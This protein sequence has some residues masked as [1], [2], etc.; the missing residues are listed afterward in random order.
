[1]KVLVAYMSQT[2][3]TKKVAQAIYE[4]IQGTKEMKEMKQVPNLDDYD[5]TFVG[6]PIM[7]YGP[8]PE[9]ANFLE[10][11]AAGK[12]IAIFITHSAPEEM[13]ELQ[14][15]I[16]KCV[17]PAAKA[18]VKGVFNCQGELGKD[19]ADF[20]LKSGNLA[21]E[22]W[23]KNRE[24]TLGQPDARRLERARIWAKDL[25]AKLDV[26]AKSEKR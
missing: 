12:N 23:A 14:E 5:L 7:R 21:L 4:A 3:Q 11:K 16:N 19:I 25:L 26:L 13:K 1:M 17:A 24:S 9:A 2:G 22:T 15:W 8:S 18:N 10:N 6:F 20:M